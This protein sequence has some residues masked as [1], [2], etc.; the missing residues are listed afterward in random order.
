LLSISES[1]GHG[2]DATASAYATIVYQC[3]CA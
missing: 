1:P 2:D 3:R